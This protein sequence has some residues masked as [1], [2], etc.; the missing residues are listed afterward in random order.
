MPGILLTISG[1]TAPELKQRIA[2]DITALTANLL[3]KEM[4]KT[5]LM[6]HFVPHEDWFIAGKSLVELQK[7]SFRLEVTVIDETVTKDQK[8]AYHQAAFAVL[9]RLIGHVH[10]HSNVHVIDCRA[11]AYGYGGLT[12]E[13]RYQHRNAAAAEAA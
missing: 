2:G 1:N 11:S 6:L 9:S 4:E 8:A 13:Y 5:M 3:G 12:Q 7:N 10:P